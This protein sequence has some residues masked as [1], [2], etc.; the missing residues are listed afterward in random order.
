MRGTIFP[1]RSARPA[2]SI[3]GTVSGARSIRRE[4][5][6]LPIIS[7]IRVRSAG[8]LN[9]TGAS[10]SLVGKGDPGRS[11]TWHEQWQTILILT[12]IEDLWRSFPPNSM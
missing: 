5:P 2:S 4:P 12:G 10:C 9:D 11:E 1:L 3:T 7:D 6:L 8:T